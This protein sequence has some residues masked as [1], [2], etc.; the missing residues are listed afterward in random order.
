MHN[1][2]ISSLLF[3]TI[4]GDAVTL[5]N[6]IRVLDASFLSLPY[7][8]KDCYTRPPTLSNVAPAYPVYT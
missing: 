8:I 5:S 3:N 7:S 4:D 1:I 6:I 2:R